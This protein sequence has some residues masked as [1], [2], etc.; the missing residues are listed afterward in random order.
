MTRRQRFGNMRQV[1]RT[2]Y[3]IDGFQETYLV[4]EDFDE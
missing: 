1:M 3:R 4:L 2:L